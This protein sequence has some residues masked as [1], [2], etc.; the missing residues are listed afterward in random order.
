MLS[1]CDDS[2]LLQTH[3]SGLDTQLSWARQICTPLLPLLSHVDELLLWS[4]YDTQLHRQ[5]SA[6]WLEILSLFSDVLIVDVCG[7]GLAVDIARVL[8]GLTGERAVE[9]LPI[10]Q[11]LAL[12][13]RDD[14]KP[15][16]KPLIDARQLSD[17]PVVV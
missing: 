14:V 9:M 1:S 16:L 8:G 3:C 4:D 12:G 2:L 7:G 13:S 17:H 11:S 15:L 6:L 10:L 5:D